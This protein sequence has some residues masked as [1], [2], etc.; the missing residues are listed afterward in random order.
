MS[1]LGKSFFTAVNQVNTK[2]QMD[3]TTSHSHGGRTRNNRTI[4][5][6]R[7]GRGAY[8][9]NWSKQA[10]G[11]HERSNMLRSCGKK[12]FLGPNKTFPIC[13]RNTCKINRKGVYA[14][15]IR[16][17]EYKTIKRKSQKYPRISRKARALLRKLY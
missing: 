17:Q 4:K 9:K 13:T 3:N 16:A 1:N 12:C 5:T 14:A 10:P 6:G 11:Y 15:Y 7:R 8:L 2:S